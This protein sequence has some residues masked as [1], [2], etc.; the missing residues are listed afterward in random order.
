MTSSGEL[1]HLTFGTFL[2]C[3]YLL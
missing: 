2:L 3:C 1:Y